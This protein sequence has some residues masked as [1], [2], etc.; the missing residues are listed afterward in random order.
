MDYTERH[1]SGPRCL[2]WLIKPFVDPQ[3]QFLL[4]DE[5]TCLEQS[6]IV[7]KLTALFSID[8]FVGGLTDGLVAY[9]FSVA[10]VGEEGLGAVFFA[11]HIFNAFCESQKTQGCMLTVVFLSASATT[12]GM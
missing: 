3:A 9:W 10:W 6:K 11:V 7:V 1:Q 5:K 4:V 2:P 12:T 8:A